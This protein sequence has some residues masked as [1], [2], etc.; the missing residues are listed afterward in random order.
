M[1]FEGFRLREGF[2]V[3]AKCVT[4]CHNF[5]FGLPSLLGLRYTVHSE[6][7]EFL[8]ASFSLWYILPRLDEN[9]L[10]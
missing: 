3:L 9:I 2:A 7:I 4:L 1:H 8:F 5:A 10:L 6:H